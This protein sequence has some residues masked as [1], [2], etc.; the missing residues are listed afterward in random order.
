M[1]DYRQTHLIPNGVIYEP[2]G[3]LLPAHIAALWR[4]IKTPREVSADEPKGKT[5]QENMEVLEKLQVEGA[6]GRQL[7][8]VAM[9]VGLLPHTVMLHRLGLEELGLAEDM[10]FDQ[11]IIPKSSWYENQDI[12]IPRTAVVY[13]LKDCPKSSRKHD[14][15]IRNSLE[16]VGGLFSPYCNISFPFFVAAVEGWGL[17]QE[18][19]YT[20]FNQSL[21]AATSCVKIIDNLNKQVEDSPHMQIGGDPVDNT[22]FSLVMDQLT[23]TLQVSWSQD[24]KKY[25]TKILERFCLWEE[26]GY[27]SLWRCV[28]GILRWGAGDRLSEIRKVLKMI[29]GLNRYGYSPRSPTQNSSSSFSPSV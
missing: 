4:T 24:G 22:I 8:D 18:S 1:H 5:L 29:P 2:D 9:G 25:Y 16:P 19:L 12:P 20:C 10:P 21:G 17:D 26:R 27:V 28:Q 3:V 15:Q 14:V 6:W 7:R 13:G 11:S 23:A